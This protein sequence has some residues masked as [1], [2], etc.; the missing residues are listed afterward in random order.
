MDAEYTYTVG[1]L[2]DTMV[3]TDNRGIDHT[4]QVNYNGSDQVSTIVVTI[5]STTYTQTFT[6]DG[7]GYVT[8]E[9]ITL[10]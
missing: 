7:S 9:D 1:G 8:N 2:V 3:I 5:D 4:F 10:S 6:Y